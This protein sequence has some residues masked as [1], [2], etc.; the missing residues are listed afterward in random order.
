MAE[1]GPQRHGVC[2]RNG[3]VHVPLDHGDDGVQDFGAV[4]FVR[5]RD[6]VLDRRRLGIAGVATI[7]G[8]MRAGVLVDRLA[9]RRGHA[10]LLLELEALDHLQ[11]RFGALECR[12]D[13]RAPARL[14]V[15]AELG[16]RR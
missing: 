13:L 2:R 8:V 14:T 3:Q 5:P 11:D 15:E 1:R 6:H 12:A 4:D 9:E 10:R 7:L 16:L